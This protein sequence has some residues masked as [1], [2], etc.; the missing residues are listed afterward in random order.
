[1]LVP[2]ADQMKFQTEIIPLVTQDHLFLVDVSPE[3]P[4]MD[5]HAKLVDQMR[6]KI[7]IILMNVSFSHNAHSTPT[8]L[9]EVLTHVE[10]ANYVQMDKF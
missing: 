10:D 5:T 7:Q 6:S 2:P 4:L 8:D 3:D 1:M 9:Q